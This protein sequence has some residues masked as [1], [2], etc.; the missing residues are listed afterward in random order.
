ML[1]NCRRF[2][3]IKDSQLLNT[4]LPIQQSDDRNNEFHLDENENIFPQL[5]LFYGHNS[6]STLRCPLFTFRRI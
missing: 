4:F 5:I 6:Y 3:F 1:I 2:L